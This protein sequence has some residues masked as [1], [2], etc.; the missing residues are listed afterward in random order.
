MILGLKAF[1]PERP[2]TKKGNRWVALFSC[3]T[4]SVAMQSVAFLAQA[5]AVAAFV[6]HDGIRSSG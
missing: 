2:A 3:A 5:I 1:Y 6:D 4:C